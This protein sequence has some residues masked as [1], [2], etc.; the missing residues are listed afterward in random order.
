M[1]TQVAWECEGKSW[2]LGLMDT[3][4]IVPKISSLTK[5]KGKEHQKAD[6]SFIWYIPLY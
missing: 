3:V 1:E 2:A 5:F 6:P 4:K